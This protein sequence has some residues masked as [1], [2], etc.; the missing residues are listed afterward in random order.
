MRHARGCGIESDSVLK[1]LNGRCTEHRATGLDVRETTTGS[2]G[3]RVS[4]ESS[5]VGPLF[6]TIS[7]SLK[8]K[9]VAVKV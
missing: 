3:W 4:L 6:P 8:S 1:K 7:A 2:T 5:T 9:V